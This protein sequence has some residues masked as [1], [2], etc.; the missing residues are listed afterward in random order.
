[1]SDN[2]F[3]KDPDAVLDYIIDWSSWLASGETITASTWTVDDG[4][5]KDS[6][7]FSD[8]ETVIWLSGGS[9]YTDY[10]CTNHIVTSGNREDDRTIII[11][12]REK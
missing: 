11:R 12:C 2:I 4:I 1:M 9:V 5:T 6:D 7:S 3:T 8:D 10:E